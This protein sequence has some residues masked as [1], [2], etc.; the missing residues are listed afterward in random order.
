MVARRIRRDFRFELP[1]PSSFDSASGFPVQGFS[2][3]YS[4]VVPVVAEVTG[5]ASGGLPTAE[6]AGFL[7]DF[8][9]TSSRVPGANIEICSAL[10]SLYAA[11]EGRLMI[12]R[13]MPA[14][15]W[16]FRGLSASSN[17]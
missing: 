13:I 17:Q 6:D 7:I 9:D 14:S 12:F 2:R 11:G 4:A 8:A 3:F 10:H 5:F 1:I 15:S 16:L